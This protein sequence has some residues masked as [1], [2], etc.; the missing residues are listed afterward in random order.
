MFIV[1][2]GSMLFFFYSTRNWMLHPCFFTQYVMYKNIQFYYVQETFRSTY[3]LTKFSFMWSFNS[4]CERT[5]WNVI[6]Y[7]QKFYDVYCLVKWMSYRLHAALSCYTAQKSMQILLVWFKK[8]YYYTK[9]VLKTKLENYQ[10]LMKK[11]FI[12]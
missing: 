1:T 11:W 8:E 7:C 10:N 2:R 12:R 9:K 5:Y 6:I 3:W 4:F